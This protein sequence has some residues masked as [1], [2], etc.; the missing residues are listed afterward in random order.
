MKEIGAYLKET[1][2]SHGVSLEEASDDLKIPSSQLDHIESGNTRAF[3]DIYELKSFVLEYAKYLGVNLEQITDEFNDFL[4]EKTSRISLSDIQEARKKME[5]EE[6][7]E[8]KIVSPYTK[9]PKPKKNY[10]PVV[11]V[12]LGI[13]LFF[14]LLYLLFFVLGHQ[15]VNRTEEL[16]GSE[17][18]V[19]RL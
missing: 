13:I 5:D 6:T 2:M 1:R 8:K 4:F 9:L 17:V 19:M 16:C 7:S 11:L 12:I 10:G 3:K 14:L 15:E 18:E